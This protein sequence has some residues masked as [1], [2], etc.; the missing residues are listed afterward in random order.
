MGGTYRLLGRYGRLEALEATARIQNL[1][2][3][4]YAEVH[5]FPALGTNLLLGLRAR[6]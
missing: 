3:E 6:F 4:Q 5:G 1:L 2:N